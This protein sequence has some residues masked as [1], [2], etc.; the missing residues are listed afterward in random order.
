M[1]LKIVKHTTFKKLYFNFLAVCILL[2]A[3]GY[4]L[5]NKKI[6]IFPEL[7]S[8]LSFKNVFIYI[9]IGVAL[10]IAFL[11]IN[12]KKALKNLGSFEEKITR[13]EK[14]YTRKLWWHVTS[15]L[16]SIIFLQLTGHIIFI[17]F[18]LFDLLSML[19]AYPSRQALQKELDEDDLLFH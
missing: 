2:L 8:A 10:I 13:F 1:D 12:N 5:H 6:H 4:V 3:V 16:S 18:G 7:F 17:Y 11:K 15:C 19:S 9:L 14:H